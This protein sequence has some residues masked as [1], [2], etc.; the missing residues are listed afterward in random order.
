M[1]DVCVTERLSP[2]NAV[3]CNQVPELHYCLGYNRQK[4]ALSVAFLEGKDLQFCK[5]VIE[6]DST[7]NYN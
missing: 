3:S 5:L 2:E 4:E 6:N 7:N 1:K